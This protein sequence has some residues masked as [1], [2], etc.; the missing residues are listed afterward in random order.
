MWL[1]E[2]EEGIRKQDAFTVYRYARLLAGTGIGSKHRRFGQI[3]AY[4]TSQ[5]VW[6][7]GLAKEGPKGSL[8][9]HEYTWTQVKAKR[10]PLIGKRPETIAIEH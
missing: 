6:A 2:L 7:Q 8:A 9:L 10:P 4:T 5:I 1:E 3:R